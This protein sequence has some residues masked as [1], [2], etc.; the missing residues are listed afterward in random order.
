MAF[1]K[2]QYSITTICGKKSPPYFISY[3]ILKYLFFGLI[4]LLKQSN[5]KKLKSKTSKQ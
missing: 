5:Q 1:L 3:L 4:I 2:H